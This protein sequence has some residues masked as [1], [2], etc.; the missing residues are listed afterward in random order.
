MT[1]V[2]FLK[3]WESGVMVLGGIA[4]FDWPP[5][6][7]PR[8]ST[9][10]SFSKYF[11]KFAKNQKVRKFIFLKSESFWYWLWV[12]KKKRESLPREFQ[13]LRETLPV[14]YGF[15]WSLKTL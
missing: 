7:R 1:K 6:H 5:N 13:N 8:S 9:N 14:F 4:R 11:L 12:I 10:L 2:A 15:Q 3:G